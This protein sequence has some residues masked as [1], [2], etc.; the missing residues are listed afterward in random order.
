MG[1]YSYI[2]V[3]TFGRVLPQRS[4]RGSAFATVATAA[5]N[6]LKANPKRAFNAQDFLDSAGVARKVTEFGR[7]KTIFSQGDPAKNVLIHSKR[8]GETF[9]S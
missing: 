4:E 8:R 7:K 6:R 5:S 2:L 3:Y 9:D 1:A